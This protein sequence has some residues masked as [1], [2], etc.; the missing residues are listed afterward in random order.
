MSE[1]IVPIFLFEVINPFSISMYLGEDFSFSN[2]FLQG[3]NLGVD[4]EGILSGSI[5]DFK[6]EFG[7]VEEFE[8]KHPGF[9]NFLP[10]QAAQRDSKIQSALFE[11]LNGLQAA[12]PAAF[13][14]NIHSSQETSI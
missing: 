9:G 3:F 11:H 6:R 8:L 2:A 1:Y 7:D 14:G 4:T 12:F 5:D 13:S 10:F